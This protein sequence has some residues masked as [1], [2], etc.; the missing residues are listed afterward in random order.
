[1]RNINSVSLIKFL[2]AWMMMK[3]P[4]LAEHMCLPR[5]QGAQ[6]LG[7]YVSSGWHM[8]G[9]SLVVQFFQPPSVHSKVEA[10]IKFM[11]RLIHSS[12]LDKGQEWVMSATRNRGG[13]Q[14]PWN[15]LGTW[16]WAFHRQQQIVTHKKGFH[17]W[18]LGSSRKGFKTWLGKAFIKP[19][20]SQ[21]SRLILHIQSHVLADSWHSIIS[22][23]N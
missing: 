7:V 5:A 15:Y 4:C 17:F 2:E 9:H 8:G 1:M 23:G 13:H 10:G 3:V 22:E 14:T 6:I 18:S 19:C 20:V 11:V 12:R 21:L 16:P